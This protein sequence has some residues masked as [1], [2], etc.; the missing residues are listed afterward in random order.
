[1]GV[2]WLLEYMAQEHAP[3]GELLPLFEGWS[4]HPMPLYVAF[5]SNRHVSAKRRVF[6]DWVVALMAQHT[7]LRQPV[8]K[9]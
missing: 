1:M 9:D 3:R 8:R 6:I 2:I 7:P 5:P 4:L